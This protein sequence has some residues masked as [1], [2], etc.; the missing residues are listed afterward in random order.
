MPSVFPLPST[1]TFPILPPPLDGNSFISP[2]SVCWFALPSFMLFLPSRTFQHTNPPRNIPV[3][4]RSGTKVE[5]TRHAVIFT[6][7]S[8]TLGHISSLLYICALSISIAAS[9]EHSFH[10]WFACEV[11]GTDLVLAP[12]KKSKDT[13]LQSTFHLKR[14]TTNLCFAHRYEMQSPLGWNTATL[15]NHLGQEI[16]IIAIQFKLQENFRQAD[17]NYNTLSLATS[18]RLK[19]VKHHTDF[20]ANGRDLHFTSLH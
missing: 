6:T 20:P 4:M 16:K 12:N 10:F 15:H 1:S 19:F 11:L 7:Q 14:F 13:H 3:I 8:L 9:W 17:C 2:L 5:L 18:H